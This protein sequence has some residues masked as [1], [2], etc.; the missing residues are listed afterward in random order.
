M[1]GGQ[2]IFKPNVIRP[3]LSQLREIAEYG[4]SA[5]LIVRHLTKA[6]REKAIYQGGGS[7]DVIG[8]ARSAI[9][10]AEHPENPEQKIVAHL[11]HNI[12]PRGSSWVYEL[13]KKEPESI[14]TLKWI[15]PS[16]LTVDDFMSKDGDGKDSALE[17][18][19]EFLRKALKDGPKAV[20]KVRS[21]AEK[22][23][24]SKRT[25]DRARRELGVKS[26]KGRKGSKGW[27]LSL[28]AE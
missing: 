11:K 4:D 6:K 1:P 28:P 16:D 18:A 25:L 14:P 24:I 5:V 19:V 3:L 21:A 2:D 20:R 10:V 9:L 7:M 8:A 22:R 15:G 12:A 17:Y 23:N 26:Y 27:F 13:V